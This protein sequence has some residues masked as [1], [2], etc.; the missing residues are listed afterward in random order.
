M[1]L[2]RTS[3]VIR[4]RDLLDIVDLSA[5]VI[6]RCGLGLAFAFAAGVVPV[7]LF[8]HWFL[9]ESTSLLEEFDWRSSYVFKMFVM[10][11]LS[12]PL[13]TAGLPSSSSS[14][15]AMRGD[16]RSLMRAG[17]ETSPQL[18]AFRHGHSPREQPSDSRRSSAILGPQSF[19]RLALGLLH[20][21]NEASRRDVAITGVFLLRP[22]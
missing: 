20:R 18:S 7:A 21:K 22:S 8:N 2:D 16:L 12:A 15:H 14:I 4:E 11:V 19:W 1:Q 9:Y 3:I 17:R 5:L 13:A 6:R 10:V